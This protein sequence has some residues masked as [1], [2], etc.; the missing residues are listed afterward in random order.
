MI[1]V[2]N[3]RDDWPDSGNKEEEEEQGNPYQPASGGRPLD[4]MLEEEKN[5]SMDASPSEVG[6]I[7]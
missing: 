5:P 7:V 1:R 3:P 2:H 4:M 6:E